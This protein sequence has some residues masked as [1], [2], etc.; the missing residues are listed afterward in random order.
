[1]IVQN[2]YRKNR[3]EMCKFIPAKYKKVLEIGCGEGTF[4]TYLKSDCEYWGLEKNSKSANIANKNSIKVIKGGFF[5]MHHMLPNNYFDLIICNDI[6]EHLDDYNLFL[7]IIKKKMT[8]EGYIIGSIPNV[9]Y[10]TNLYNLFFLKDWK[11]E[12]EGILDKT[13]L[14]F[15]TKK[16]LVEIL[17]KHKFNIIELHGI[18]KINLSIYSSKSIIKNILSF[19]FG[20]D[21]KYLQFGFTL[22]KIN[23]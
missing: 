1:M 17:T 20:N 2:Y 7:S 3:I 12:D 13:H 15:F 6:I 21:S 11:Y 10:I 16:S 5:D 23:N 18:N 8:K 22:K 4:R 14:R 19:F 9:R